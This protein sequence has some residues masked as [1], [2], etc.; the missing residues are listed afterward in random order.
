MRHTQAIYSRLPPPTLAGLPS[1]IRFLECPVLKL[2]LPP[3]DL[4]FRSTSETQAPAF[5]G[6]IA[7]GLANLINYQGKTRQGCRRPS[8]LMSIR[9]SR[10]TTTRPSRLVTTRPSRLMCTRPSRLKISGWTSS[11]L[12][13]SPSNR[14]AAHVFATTPGVDHNTQAVGRASST[15]T[16]SSLRKDLINSPPFPPFALPSMIPRG[17]I[18]R[19]RLRGLPPSPD[20]TR[21]DL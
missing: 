16:Y 3:V 8:R 6:N 17:S 7:L 15:T 2:M 1:F 5:L 14:S 4:A 11:T 13:F 10:Y 21:R 12:G 9:P 20:S 18:T 19:R